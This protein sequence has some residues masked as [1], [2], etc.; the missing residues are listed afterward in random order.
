M[1][2]LAGLAVWPTLSAAG[3]EN[4]PTQ[5]SPSW[6]VPDIGGTWVPLSNSSFSSLLFQPDPKPREV[7]KNHSMQRC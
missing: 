4:C 5:V 2:R 6:Q 7:F 1:P 3:L